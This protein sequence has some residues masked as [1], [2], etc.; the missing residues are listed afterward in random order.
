M[1]KKII[2]Y[3]LILLLFL[4]LF[5]FYEIIGISNKTVNRNFISLDINNI[6]NPQI[7][8]FMRNLDNYYSGILLLVNKN[9]K[10]YY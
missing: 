2:N 9:H 8:K 3:I 4:T 1:N 7:K 6:R 5:I 10:E